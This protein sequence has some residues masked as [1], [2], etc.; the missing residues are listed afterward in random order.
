MKEEKGKII[1]PA[2]EPDERLIQLIK[3]LYQESDAK[4]IVVNDGSGRGAER[5]FQEC[6][7]YATVLKHHKN[8]GKGKAVKTALEYIMNQNQRGEIVIADA[9]GQHKVHDILHLLETGIRNRKSLL[10][11]SR[12]FRGKIPLRS[13]LGNQ[14]TRGIFRLL[15][16]KWLKDTQT[17]LRAFDC[18]FIPRLLAVPGERYEYETNVL[19]MCIKEKIHIME[20]PVE[21]IYLDGNKSSH[22]H[23][24]KDSVRIYMDLMKFAAS[25]FVSFCADFFL[26]S[27]MLYAATKLH[28][29][30]AEAA[31]NILARIGSGVLNYQLNRRYVF[32]ARKAASHSAAKYAVLASAVLLV[33]TCLLV[34]LVESKGINGWTAKAAVETSMFIG[35][36]LVQKLLIFRKREKPDK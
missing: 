28:L 7:A 5:I 19:L 9:D 34:W 16:G 33:N 8:Y 30:F 4:L 1:I 10:L 29:S 32:G 12:S 18:S 24:L 35:S 17:G 21:T 25:S 6:E 11:G 22:F 14:I 31:C 26:Y 23:V 2:Y 15:S 3:E 27:L 36:F 13:R 20:V